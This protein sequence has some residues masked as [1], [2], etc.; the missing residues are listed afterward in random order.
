MRCARLPAYIAFQKTAQALDLLG[1]F[2]TEVR[3]LA[4]IFFQ[5]EQQAGIIFAKGNQSEVLQGTFL[6]SP[7][8][9]PVG[10]SIIANS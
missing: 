2:R 5:V 4:G 3:G 8:L 1:V 9:L 10:A 6:L 7:P